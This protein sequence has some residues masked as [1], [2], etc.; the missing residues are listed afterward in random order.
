MYRCETS[1]SERHVAALIHQSEDG[2][3][4]AIAYCR[5]KGTIL[6]ILLP[7]KGGQP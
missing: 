5:Q 2:R 4:K 3:K 6:P 7:A 1:H